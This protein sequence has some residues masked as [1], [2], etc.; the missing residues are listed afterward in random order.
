MKPLAMVKLMWKENKIKSFTSGI[1]I[2]LIRMAIFGPAKYGTYRLLINREIKK[3]NTRGKTWDQAFNDIPF[4][5]RVLYSATSGV[6]AALAVNPMDLIMI[7]F[8][9]DMTLPENKRRNYKN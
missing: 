1:G 2:N 6:V 4:K 7:R 5:K 8:Q 3:T 9:S